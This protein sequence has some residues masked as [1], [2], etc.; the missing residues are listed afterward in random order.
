MYKIGKTNCRKKNK[1]EIRARVEEG[2]GGIYLIYIL[3]LIWS[4][5]NRVL[6]S[7]LWPLI[8][9]SNPHT[10]THKHV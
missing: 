4:T 7:L 8:L 3:T 2:Q 9:F 10:L 6:G 1:Q 5:Y